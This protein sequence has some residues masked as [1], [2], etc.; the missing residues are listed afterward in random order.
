[1]E[2]PSDTTQVLLSNHGGIECNSLNQFMND[3]EINSNNDGITNSNSE[4]NNCLK[5]SLYYSVEEFFNFQT[6]NEDKLRFMSINCQSLRA[7]YN[8]LKYILDTCMEKGA[9]LHALILQETH[10]TSSSTECLEISGY[11]L[12]NQPARINRFGGLAIYLEENLSYEEI[13]TDISSDIF[14]S[15]FL[16]IKLN[17]RKSLVIGNIYRRPNDNCGNYTQFTNKLSMIM[18]SLQLNKSEILLAGDFNINLLKVRERTS[19]AEFLESILSAGYLPHITFPTRF[20]AN[21]SYSLIDNFFSK[22][23]PVSA[24]QESGILVS[25][26]SDHFGYFTTFDMKLVT[27]KKKFIKIRK[28]SEEAIQNFV[29]SL[30]TDNL[31]AKL[32]TNEYSNPDTNYNIFHSEVQKALNEH[33]PERTVKFNKHKH[34]KEDWMTKGLLSSIK[35]RDSL[36]LNFRAMNK[37]HTLFAYA[38]S[39]LIG[40]SS[41]TRSSGTLILPS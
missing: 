15:Q 7:K 1:M 31:M 36:L 26:V 13:L 28:E 39:Q 33:I 38:K 23:T 17:N 35:T 12:I 25:S 41:A 37:E 29:N 18:K 19:F 14:E 5:N 24:S 30:E 4:T 27:N 11:K 20:G 40:N 2:N 21:N 8:G 10:L 6:I 3:Y 9:P 16:K 22:L 32:D 34:F